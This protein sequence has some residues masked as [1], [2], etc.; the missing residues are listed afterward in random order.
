MVTSVPTS[1]STFNGQAVALAKGIPDAAVHV[2]QADMTELFSLFGTL[3]GLVQKVSYLLR[4]HAHAVIGNA[5]Q[6]VPGIRIGGDIQQ[7]AAVAAL[8][9]QPVE[10]GVF[11][12]RLQGEPGDHAVPAKGLAFNAGDLN[13]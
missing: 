13:L 6:Y 7:H 8:G 10:D 4:R 1:S 3:G 11:H 5:Q 2:P 9:F 12:Q